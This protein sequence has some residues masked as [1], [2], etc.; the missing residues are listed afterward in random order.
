ML[1]DWAWFVRGDVNY[2]G[3]QWESDYNFAKINDF[4]RINARVGFERDSLT[5]ELFA[6]NLFND[7]NWES[8]FRLPNL[9]LPTAGVD[10]TPQGI[11]V[12][13][14]DRREV[15]LRATFKF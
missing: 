4:V 11:G 15:G 9:T 13:P 12:L 6:K 3:K 1:D 8:A 14:P 5:L 7:K 2:T 10:F